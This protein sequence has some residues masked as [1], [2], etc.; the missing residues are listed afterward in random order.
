M[1]RWSFLGSTFSPHVKEIGG[2]G[3]ILFPLFEVSTLREKVSKK[4]IANIY[5]IGTNNIFTY[6]NV[7]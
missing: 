5:S 4:E 6:V 2:R 7:K 1:I 3:G